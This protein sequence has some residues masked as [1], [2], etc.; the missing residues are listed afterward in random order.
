M[1]TQIR[2]DGFKSFR[3]FRLDVPPTLIMLGPNGAGKSNLL[4]ALRLVAAA[5][6]GGLADTARGDSRLTPGALL[7]RF[8]PQSED[9]A[10]EFVVEVSAVSLCD[11]G[12]LPITVRLSMQALPMTPPVLGVGECSVRLGDLPAPGA[13]GP[14]SRSELREAMDEFS[15]LARDTRGTKAHLDVGKMQLGVV[16]SAVVLRAGVEEARGLLRRLALAES[17]SWSSLVLDPV[18]M[19]QPSAGLSRP[20]LGVDGGYLA[21]VLARIRSDSPAAWRR[22]LGDLASLVDGVEDVRTVSDERRQE[23]D[24]EVLF[25]HTGWCAPPMLSDGTLRMIGLL[26]AAADPLRAPTVCVE[27]I[28]NG[29]YPERVAELVRRLGRAGPDGAARQLIATTHSPALLAALRHDLSGSL[30]FLDQADH[31]DPVRRTVSRTTVA[32]PLR[33]YDPDRAP[34]ETVSPESVDRLLRRLGRGEGTA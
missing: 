27:E 24:F 9:R 14:Y 18:V 7:H 32:R 25:S 33:A 10:E 17:A 20:E 12:P 34:G 21:A 11:Y 31:V 22:L 19:R 1:I 29:M 16:D 26:A 13:T 23:L 4:D 3:D 30:V 6:G 15:L 5:V 28:E 2:I 8:G